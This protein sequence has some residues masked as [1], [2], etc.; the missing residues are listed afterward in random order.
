MNI[1]LD[2]FAEIYRN[3]QRGQKVPFFNTNKFV[4]TIETI[5]KEIIHDR[6]DLF[7]V[8]VKTSGHSG[9]QKV[10]VLID[11]DQ[12]IGID[13]CS[14]ISRKLSAIIDE[15]DLIKGKFILEVSSPGI[16]YPLKSERQYKKNVGRKLQVT[17]AEKEFKG[18]LIT[19]SG[20]S[21]TI[22]SEKK[23]KNKIETEEVEI[24]FEKI[25]KA[26]VLVS[27]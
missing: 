12:G 8:D 23:V 24:P 22:K 7:L 18:E 10:L 9:S 4:E 17:T 21:I 26:K 15:K 6:K 3:V 13:D 20:D 19:I 1:Y 2:N 27:F 14:K 11:S 5:V 25:D 16:D